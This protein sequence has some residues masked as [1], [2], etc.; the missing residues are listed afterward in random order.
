MRIIAGLY[1]GRT[2]GTVRDL[3][4]RPATD[5]VRQTI[6]DVLV[7]RM[8]LQ[9]CTV[10]DLFAGSGSLGLEALSRGAGRVTFVESSEDAIAYL[11]RNIRTLGCETLTEIVPLDA[12]MYLSRT[13]S[14]FDLVFADPPY[15]FA[16]LAAVPDI[17]FAK[18][19]LAPDGFLMME[20]TTDLHFK[21]T[22]AYRIGPEK[23]FG[24]TL[25]TFFQSNPEHTNASS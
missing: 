11:E 10:L 22:A 3:S 14:Q 13:R 9:G 2:I 16:E 25:V 8:D 7:H 5:R 6:F 1:K 24:R 18:K 20:H 15:R 17:V 21:S 12:M 4:V 19:V 23:K